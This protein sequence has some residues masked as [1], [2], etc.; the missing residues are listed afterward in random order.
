MTLKATSVLTNDEKIIIEKKYASKKINFLSDVERLFAV[1]NILLKI[2]VITGWVLPTSELMNVLIDQFYK[3]IIEDYSELNPDEIEF[4]FRNKGT[5]LKDWGK[6]I[7]LNL[8]DEILI[9]YVNSRFEISKKEENLIPV[10][11]DK[12]WSNEEIINQYRFEIESCFQALRKGYRPL[13]HKYFE[14]TLRNDGMM[15]EDENISEFL[16][17]KLNSMVE[18]LYIK[19][20]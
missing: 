9:P 11:E 20:N 13:I 14:E 3:K 18:N 8:I 10:K 19:E 12:L 16:V 4:A 7:N 17:R 1:K 6:E 5:I 15:N 2:H